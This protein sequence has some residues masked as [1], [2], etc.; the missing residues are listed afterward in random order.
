[1]SIYVCIV[2]RAQEYAKINLVA[3]NTLV[4]YFSKLQGQ[5][6]MCPVLFF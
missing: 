5:I 6:E 2:S 4:S 3:T 1:M